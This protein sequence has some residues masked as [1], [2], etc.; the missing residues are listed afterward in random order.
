MLEFSLEA[1]GEIL[2]EA[3]CHMG[4]ACIQELLKWTREVL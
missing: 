1:F 2:F 3:I 4:D